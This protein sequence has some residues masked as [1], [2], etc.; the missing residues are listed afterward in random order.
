MLIPLRC[1]EVRKGLRESERAVTVKDWQGKRDFLRFEAGFLHFEG[2]QFWFPVG[3]I[4]EDSNQGV[5]LIEYPQESDRGNWR[6]WVST[7]DL[8]ECQPAIV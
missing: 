5:V 2:D 4:A 8:L 7:S 3:K 6:I 1:Q